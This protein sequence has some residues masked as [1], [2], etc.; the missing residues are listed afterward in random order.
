MEMVAGAILGAETE[1]SRKAVVECFAL[2]LVISLPSK[3]IPTPLSFFPV[4]HSCYNLRLARL[5]L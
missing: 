3:S 4:A 1:K 2:F 5:C